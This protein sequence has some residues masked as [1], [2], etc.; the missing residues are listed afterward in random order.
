[1][2][3]I[4]DVDEDGFLG[5]SDLL[6]FYS[7]IAPTAEKKLEDF[8]GFFKEMIDKTGADGDLIKYEDLLKS[9]SMEQIFFLLAD[10]EQF[11]N[12][13]GFARTVED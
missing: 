2:H 9:G 12:Y 5:R 8:E 7:D 3:K 6:Y 4:Y 11:Q 1:M 10:Y 13:Y